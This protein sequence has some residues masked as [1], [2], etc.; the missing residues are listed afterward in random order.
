VKEFNSP[1]RR[2]RPPEPLR[3]STRPARISPSGR[4][5]FFEDGAFLKTTERGQD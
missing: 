3:R 4:V 2:T 5:S 1:D